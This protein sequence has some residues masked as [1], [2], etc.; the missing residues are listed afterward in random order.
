M[1]EF[2]RY[3]FGK[4]TDVEFVNF[5]FAHFLPIVITAVLLVLLYRY[6]N[7]I[8]NMKN[9]QVF[10]YI[11]AFALVISDM[12][13]FWRLI[14]MPSLSPNPVDH[15]PITVCG[16]VAIF[17]SYMLI[18][19][20]QTLFDVCYFWAL[21]GSIFALITPTVITF[22]GPTRFRYYQFWFEHLGGY[23]A[24]FYMIFVHKMRPNKWSFVKAY[25]GLTLLA[26]FAY[27]AN[28]I[29]GPGANYLFMARP[30]DTPS[31]LD[32]LPPNFALRLLVMASI[33]TLMF[34]L[35]YLPWYI[36]DRRMATEESNQQEEKVLR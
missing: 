21:T 26:A 27:F 1:K 5:S 22:T 30:E 13:Y 29:I 19:K 3:F 28:R 10:R 32:I 6:R 33:I 4:G 12:S 15:L 11:L 35:A 17:A 31:I 34:I 23:L 25:G 2:L 14:A 9:E 18:G 7:E 16:W 36:K 24:I 8:R 20:S